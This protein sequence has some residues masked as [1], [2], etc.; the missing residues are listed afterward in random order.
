MLSAAPKC[1]PRIAWCQNLSDLHRYLRLA[2]NCSTCSGKEGVVVRRRQHEP[3]K[4]G[5]L[6]IKQH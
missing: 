2:K 5:D 6:K 3:A 1:S 4:R